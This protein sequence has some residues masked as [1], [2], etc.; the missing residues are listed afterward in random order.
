M[1]VVAYIYSDPVPLQLPDWPGWTV[2]RTYQDRATSSKIPRPEFQNLLKDCAQTPTDYLLVRQLE[3]LG[4]AIDEIITNLAALEKLNMQLV[5]IEQ[6]DAPIP[7]AELLARF[8]VL[9]QFQHSR[10]IQQGHA[11][12]RVKT[13]PPPGKPPYGYKRSRNRYVVDRSTAP[14]VKTFFEQYLLFAS[15]RGAVRFIGKKYGK[16]IAVSTGQKW[17]TNPVYRGDLAYKNGD[18]IADT[19]EAIVSREEAAQVDRLLRRNQQFA[20]RSASAPRSLSGL[21]TCAK[22][23]SSMTITRVVPAKVRQKNTKETSEY[24][25]I[26][27]TQC[28]EKCKAIAYDTVLQATIDRVC[29]DLPKAL[30]GAQLPDLDRFK[31]MTNAEIERQQQV[32]AQIPQLL[33]QQILDEQSAALRS[34]NLRSEIAQLRQRLDR[35]PPVNLQATAS[36]VSL[37]Q[38]WADLSETERRFYLR[39]FIR[40]IQIV[41]DEGNW[42]IKLQFIF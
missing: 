29:E 4:D 11:R 18:V 17:L 24:L 6:A 34:Y 20:K 2:D 42:Q 38:F 19:H 32:L 40:E 9:Q 3:D 35:L 30:S 31:Q 16:K 5:A 14:I 27:P 33:E 41:R 13:K 1:R 28:P 10:R 37:P 39:E 7:S 26:R 8:Q 22:C 15:L 23:R 12:N 25:Y 21:V 36:T